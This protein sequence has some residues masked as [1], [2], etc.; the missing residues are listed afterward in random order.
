MAGVAHSGHFTFSIQGRRPPSQSETV[1]DRQNTVIPTEKWRFFLQVASYRLEVLYL[2]IS[3]LNV[4]FGSIWFLFQLN[5][6]TT[7]K[8]LTEETISVLGVWTAIASK[9]S[10]GH[11]QFQHKSHLVLVTQVLSLLSPCIFKSYRSL[12]RFKVPYHLCLFLLCWSSSL[13]I[14]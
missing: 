7:V 1:D 5:Q 13:V 10:I 2:P 4:P 3:N 6:G 8:L 11:S 14:W 9:K 12:L